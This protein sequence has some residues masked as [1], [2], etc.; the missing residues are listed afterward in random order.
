[1]VATA[2]ART[3]L[4]GPSGPACAMEMS[5]HI[6]SGPQGSPSPRWPARSLP[7]RATEP[8]APARLCCLSAPLCPISPSCSRGVPVPVPVPCG[9]G[10]DGCWGPGGLPGCSR[11]LLVPA[12]SSPPLAPR[13]PRRQHRG[14]HHRHHPPGLAH[15]RA[16][17]RSQGPHPHPTGGEETAL[18]GAPGGTG[19]S[20]GGCWGG[21]AGATRHPGAHHRHAALRLSCWGWWICRTWRALLLTT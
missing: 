1:M 9:R 14:S 12:A 10:L 21:S 3:P 11:G 18:P 5:Y 20:P 19:T 16:W 6:H 2:K 15:A 4:L 13:L 7:H 17:Q 8:P